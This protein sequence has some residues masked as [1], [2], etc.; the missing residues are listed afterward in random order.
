MA[1]RK[2]Y[3]N[4][5]AQGFTINTGGDLYHSEEGTLAAET[6]NQSVGMGAVEM[7]FCVEVIND[8]TVSG[9]DMTVSFNA[10]GNAETTVKA[11]ESRTFDRLAKVTSIWIG[12]GATT[13]VSYRIFIVGVSGT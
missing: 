4:L 7:A 13:T 6:I 8:E 3:S 2:S 5:L 11:G 10:A 9:R 1:K 12:N